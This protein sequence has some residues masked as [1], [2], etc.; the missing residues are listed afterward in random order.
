MD[1]RQYSLVHLLR[2]ICP[3][4]SRS[5]LPG[6]DVWAFTRSAMHDVY[7]WHHDAACHVSL[8][9]R[10]TG[11]AA[12]FPWLG[13]EV[14]LIE[15]VSG[16]YPKSDPEHVVLMFYTSA[17]FPLVIYYQVGSSLVTSLQYR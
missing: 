13:R 15:S 9:L 17:F 8:Q 2:A 16:W 1:D 6:Q 14:S 5:W 3:R 11:H 10:W 4:R 12:S 7:L